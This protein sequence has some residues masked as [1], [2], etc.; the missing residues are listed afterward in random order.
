MSMPLAEQIGRV[1]AGHSVH[2]EYNACLVRALACTLL[3]DF[4]RGNLAAFQRLA[5][6]M[7]LSEEDAGYLTY[8]EAAKIITAMQEAT[9]YCA[10]EAVELMALPFQKYIERRQNDDKNPAQ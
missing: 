8:L 2:P 10:D 5:R 6:L 9:P 1:K 3:K 7:S 4:F